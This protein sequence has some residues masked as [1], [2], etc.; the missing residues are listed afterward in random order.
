MPE[1]DGG[2]TLQQQPPADRKKRRYAAL[3]LRQG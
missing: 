3:K 2:K 1:T